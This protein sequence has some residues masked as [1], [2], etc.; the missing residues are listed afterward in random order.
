MKESLY[1]TTEGVVYRRDNTLMFVN[2]N[3]K[4]KLPIEN[5]SDIFCLASVTIKSGALKILFRKNIPVHYFS[6]FGF[7]LGSFYPREY[8]VSGDLLVKQVNHYIEK[9][10]RIYLAR[11]FVQGIKSNVLRVFDDYSNNQK[12]KFLKELVQNVSIEYEDI[13]SLRSQEG[14]IWNYL[15]EM[16]GKANRRFLFSRR[17]KRPPTNEINAL[18]SFGN[19]ILYGTVLTE[20]YTTQLNPTIS[21]LHEPSERRFSLALDIADVFKPLLVVR[22]IMKIVNKKMIDERD[23]DKRLNGCYLLDRG[24]RIFLKEYDAKLKTTIYHRS[25]NK[26]VSYRWLIRLE[27]YKLIR[28]FLGDKKYKSFKMWW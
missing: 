20:I 28:H 18:L 2:R 16:M 1:L 21:Y 10:K 12:I 24:K 27:L 11:E 6:R 9:E 25:L 8:L 22:T 5:I 14:K 26:K 19:T 23:F 3:E 13:S 15:Y 7:Y 4:K 17:E